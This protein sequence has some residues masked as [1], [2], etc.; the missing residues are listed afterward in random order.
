MPSCLLWSSQQTSSPA[1]RETNHTTVYSKDCRLWGQADDDVSL[2]LN[3]TIL[4]YQAA[5]K[6]QARSHAR[7]SQC[8]RLGISKHVLRSYTVN[9]FP[10]NLF[11]NK[12]CYRRF[13]VFRKNS[14]SS[15]W[16]QYQVLMSDNVHTAGVWCR[17]QDTFECLQSAIHYFPSGHWGFF[18]GPDTIWLNLVDFGP[19]QFPKRDKKQC[20]Q[21]QSLLQNQTNYH[22]YIFIRG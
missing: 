22:N 18:P 8:R 3:I 10:N 13:V 9:L 12:C 6:E 20:K 21:K 19:S 14:D 17:K 7:A 4:M 5:L 1:Q 15:I 2:S 11:V 16:R